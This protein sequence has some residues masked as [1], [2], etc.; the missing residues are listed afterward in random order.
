MIFELPGHLL[1]VFF[2]FADGEFMK[3]DLVYLWCDG[4]DA[5]WREKK[6]FWQKKYGKLA[7]DVAGESRFVQHDELR[8]S[9]RSVELYMPWINHVFIV[10]DGQVPEWLDTDNPK[11]S[12]VDHR[13]IMPSDSLPTFNSNAIE[14]CL[15]N[16]PGLSEHF[17]YANDDM[18][19]ARPLNPDFFFAPDGRPYVFLQPQNIYTES[20]YMHQIYYVQNLIKEKFG[21]D[22][23]FEPHHNIDAYRLSDIKKCIEVFKAEFDRTVH[24][25]FR[26]NETMQRS[27]WGY[28]ALATGNG[29]WVKNG[30]RK[31]QHPD[32]RK[33]RERKFISKYFSNPKTI[34]GWVQKGLCSLFCLN[35]N[36]GLRKDERL[37][38]KWELA[39]LFP[40][41]S[42]FEKV[43]EMQH[44][45][46][47]SVIVPVY[48]AGKYLKRCLDSLTGQTLKD[49]EIICVNDGSDDNSPDILRSY[50]AHD[51]RIK[52][53]SFEKMGPGGC[54]NA[55]VDAA[56][57]EYVCFVDADDFIDLDACETAYGKIKAEN[58][59]VLSFNA[60]EISKTGIR[61]IIYF[62]G[63]SE[64]T[65]NWKDLNENIF[66]SPFH[67]WHFLFKRDFLRA[68]AVYFADVYWC[69]DVPFVLLSLLAA[70]KIVLL[71]DCFYHYC[72]NES[73][74]V[75]AGGD[76]RLSVLYVVSWLKYL[77]AQ[78]KEYAPLQKSLYD[79]VC[80]HSC[81]A[82]NS[83]NETS[84]HHFCRKLKETVDAKTFLKIKK[85]CSTVKIVKTFGL[86]LIKTVRFDNV[87]RILFCNV[88]V[89]SIRR[90]K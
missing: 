86:P 49:I 2:I 57:G 48:N 11:I 61:R 63:R 27:V 60:L 33:T 59:E 31:K 39:A 28:Y 18:F 37:K 88:P 34:A 21:K 36:E 78:K 79:W 16:I 55:A 22:Y 14:A 5:V 84:R 15:H 40:F 67:S 90:K 43:P 24:Q 17:L 41:A 77:F 1:G 51:E 4:N 64:K 35:D 8:F 23:P 70:K 13:E 3:I 65:I 6:L 25:R 66:S 68:N 9:L 12:I 80:I 56:E 46:K 53:I 87:L 52:I 74:L 76:T 71:P 83:L 45:Y 19:V 42:S 20:V 10:T 7:D 82:Y 50:A 54:R 29:I 38:I 44:K 89:I 73:S 58:A 85:R 81:F 69:E 62:G 32:Y 47:V 75:C 72:R 26:E 30:G